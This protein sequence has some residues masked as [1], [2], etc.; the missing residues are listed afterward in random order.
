MYSI[1]MSGTSVSVQ[2]D[3]VRI[4]SPSD[5]TVILHSLNISQ[6]DSET[7]EQWTIQLHRASS[8]GT[9]TSVTARPF[10]EGDS[11]FGGTAVVDLSVDTTAGNTLWRESFN[12]LNGLQIF[13]TPEMQIKI[14]P[15]QRIVA[16]LSSTPSTGT[17][18]NLVAVIEE[19]GG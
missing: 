11:A 17:P 12:I 4:S 10:A 19:D 15:S 8:D 13:P 6:D 18:I 14:S 7:S 3:L 2:K 5:S 9:G 16:R 1:V